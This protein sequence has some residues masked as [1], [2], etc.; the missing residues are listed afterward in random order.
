MYST[1]NL[2]DLRLLLNEASQ[3]FFICSYHFEFKGVKLNETLDIKSQVEE[4][5]EVRIDVKIDPY[6]ERTAR[7]HVKKVQEFISHP[8]Q[9]HLLFSIHQ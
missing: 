2:L 5:E 8:Y 4:S 7:Y 3:L 6:D 9:Y 1:D